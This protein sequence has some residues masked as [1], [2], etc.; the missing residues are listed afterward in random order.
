MSFMK[1]KIDV[2]LVISWILIVLGL[3]AGGVIGGL[4]GAVV[5]V[6]EHRKQ[7]KAGRAKRDLSICLK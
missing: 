2:G 3:V 7:V 4:V 1:K 6:K 5:L